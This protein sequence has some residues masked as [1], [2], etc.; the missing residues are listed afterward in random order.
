[1]NLSNYIGIPYKDKGKDFEGLDCFGMVQL[2]YKLE[3]N[4][5]LPEYLYSSSMNDNSVALAISVNKKTWESVSIPDKDDIIVFNIKGLPLH[6]G[7]YLGDG[8]FLHSFGG[9]DTCIES[10]DSLRWNKRIEGFYRWKQ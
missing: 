2:Y 9:T 4:V 3:K 10:L 5:I 7:I 1:M 6:T 8:D